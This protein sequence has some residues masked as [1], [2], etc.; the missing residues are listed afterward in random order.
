MSNLRE[1]GDSLRRMGENARILVLTEA[2]WGIPM[3]WVGFYSSLYMKSLGLSEVEIGWISGIY[4][5][6]Q[7]LLPILGG[8][9]SDKWG[10]KRTFM[11]FDS[12]AWLGSTFVWM[13]ALDIRYALLA[14][15]INGL[16]NISMLPWKCL[17]VEG[18]PPELRAVAYSIV[19]LWWLIG[20]LTA[21]LAGFMIGLYGV[22]MG[23]KLLYGIAFFLMTIMF[24]LRQM[25]LRE[26]EIGEKLMEEG[27]SLADYLEVMK[28]IFSQKELSLLML[29]SVMGTLNY[30]IW[31]TFFTLF[32][33]DS[34]A[35]C[36][37]ASSI[38]II[39]SV[40][41]LAQLIFMLMFMQTLTKTNIK[42][43]L[44]LTYLS[45]AV[46]LM[47]LLIIPPGQLYLVAL[48]SIGNA[49]ASMFR[50]PLMEAIT[51]NVIDRIDPMA[52]AR[53]LALF[54]IV[55]ALFSIPGGPLGGYMYYADPRLPFIMLALF[56]CLSAFLTR[57]I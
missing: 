50:W 54:S 9:F 17:M 8:Y 25:Y 33:V 26:S 39:P 22:N 18:T 37:D 16:T 52:R 31:S 36:L 41:S 4:S 42:N 2:F 1:I 10:R 3:A 6:T 49:L 38:S 21:P 12:I 40:S 53:I 15:L 27:A 48:V 57:F 34:R 24:V 19:Q 29:I 14:T 13:I 20:S 43:I 11:I 55:A 47:F 56:N 44:S 45:S 30:T 5:I 32:L 46:A 28:R 51:A 7:A 23:C 35:L